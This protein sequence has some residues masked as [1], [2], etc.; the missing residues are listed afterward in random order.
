[1]IG[2]VIGTVCNSAGTETVI[3]SGE[4]VDLID[5]SRSPC[6]GIANALRPSLPRIRVIARPLT[7]TDWARGA[8]VVAIQ[9]HLDPQIRR[10]A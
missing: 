3:L 9:H 2:A 7:F 10:S 4:G 1:M 5:S 6:A 8:S